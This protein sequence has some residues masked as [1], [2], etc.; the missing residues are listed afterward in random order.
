MLK[1]NL[2]QWKILKSEEEGGEKSVYNWNGDVSPVVHQYDRYMPFPLPYP[3]FCIH[4]NAYTAS[5][6]YLTKPSRNHT[7]RLI[8]LSTL[9]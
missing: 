8:V 3:L 5:L 6:P 4:L 2:T 9:V 7:I 1:L